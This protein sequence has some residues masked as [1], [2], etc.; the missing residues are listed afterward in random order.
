MV[1]PA[2]DHLKLATGGCKLLRRMNLARP[3]SIASEPARIS[4]ASG[5]GNPFSSKATI[6]FQEKYVFIR[7]TCITA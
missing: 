7:A 4:K 1:K 5:I 3:Q 6:E 2:N